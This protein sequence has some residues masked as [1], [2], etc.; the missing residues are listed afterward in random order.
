MSYP[1][2]A[3]TRPPAIRQVSTSGDPRALGHSHGEQ[4]AETIAEGLDQWRAAIAADDRDPDQL[5]TDLSQRAGFWAAVEQHLP[6]L[7]AEV[8]GIAAGAGQDLGPV[9]A[10]NCLDEAWWWGAHGSGC[11]VVAVSD[12][13]S[14]PPVAGQTMDL[15]T[16]MDGTQVA[17]R[18]APADGPRQ[19][20][21]SRAGMVGL[22]GANDTGLVVL[23]NTLEEL[24]VDPDGVPVAFV[25]RA[26][27]AEQTLDDAVAVLHRLPHASG[28]SYTLTSRDGVRGFECG[29]GVVVEYTNDPERPA[30]RWHTNH[31][32]AYRG[33]VDDAETDPIDWATTS[34]R[35]RLAHLTETLEAN[36]DV[37]VADL[38]S[39][40]SDTDSGICMFPG[41]WRPDGF[42]FGSVIA[43]LGEPVRVRMAGGPPDRSPYV[44]VDFVGNE[45]TAS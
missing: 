4:A 14:G 41:R 8:E 33:P 22:C 37:G 38:E 15:D 40:F 44:D 6:W 25:V 30:R 36:D 12:A 24:P 9:F 23:V 21:L 17:L 35:P 29:A 20:L 28:Q 1:A 32:L 13:D 34:S 43:E 45:T 31:P 27:L 11:S 18:L 39:L 10:T 19:V 2:T 42:T 16:W 3:A 7:A 26:L 5:I